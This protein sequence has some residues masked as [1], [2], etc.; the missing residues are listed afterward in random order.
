MMM[1]SSPPPPPI[2]EEL[3][4][5]ENQDSAKKKDKKKK[6]RSK[7]RDEVD[8]VNGGGHNSLNRSRK[9]SVNSLT[10]RNGHG[11]PRSAPNK[12]GTF[13]ARGKGSRTMPHP[14][15]PP[16]MMF[17]PP[18]P[19]PPYGLP[20][21]L[22]P[23]PGHPIYGMMPPPPPR[24]SMEEP[25]YM[26]HNT[27]PLSPVAS[28]QPG[29]FP[30]EAYYNNQQHHPQQYATIDKANKYRKNKSNGSKGTSKNSSKQPSSDSNNEDSEFGAGIYKKG[31][32]NE[33]AFSYSIRN[34]QR[35]RSYGSLSNMQLTPNGEVNGDVNNE[36][37]MHHMMNELD[38][39]EDQIE[40]S[41]VPPGF[42]EG[43]GGHFPP[44]PPHM[45]YGAPP[46]P[47]MMMQQQMMP[48]QMIRMQ[49]GGG[50]GKKN[51]R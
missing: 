38:L 19:P 33:R 9:H 47:H 36:K 6:R 34:E 44:P 42:L 37:V 22:M 4:A 46:P 18:P 27:R 7:S 32:I 43:R 2:P 26:P 25:I 41:E 35:S 11:P 10:M 39:G 49:N 21:H 30:H 20:P 28:Y 23:P 17:G 12:A 1:P 48:E 45:M 13:S 5:K 24:G 51:K 16:F 8:L 15:V 3:Q 50:G 31:H 14:P 29:H 40:R